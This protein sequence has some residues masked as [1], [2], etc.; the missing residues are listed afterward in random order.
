MGY[1]ERFDYEKMAQ[2]AARERDALHALLE[3]R[4]Q[5]IPIGTDQELTWRRE[6]GTLYAMYLEQRC[7]ALELTRRA[8]K[9][10]EEEAY[11]R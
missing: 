1:T 5:E 11:A 7:M 3:K 8:Q 9:R 6:N 10:R 4:R 2:D